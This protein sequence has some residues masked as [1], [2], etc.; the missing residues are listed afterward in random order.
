MD[1]R[2]E[3]FFHHTVTD[4]IESVKLDGFLPI[5]LNLP[6]EVRQDILNTLKDRL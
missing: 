5:W 3:Q 4:F 6:S 1:D 2:R